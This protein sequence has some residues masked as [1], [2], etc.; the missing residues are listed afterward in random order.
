[1]TKAIIF[2][3]DGVIVSSD[4]PRWKFLKGLLSKR[5]YEIEESY[6]KKTIGKTT[7]LALE[8]ILTE[9]NG[10]SELDSILVE[11]SNVYRE[12]IVQ[13]ILPVK[14]TINFIK[15]YEGSAKLAVAS[16]T[17]ERTLEKILSAY[18]IF[19]KF[20]LVM[21][22]DNI[23]KHKPNP[24]IYEKVLTTLTVSPKDAIVF[25]DSPIGAQAALA[26]GTRCYVMLHE[27]NKKEDF[28]HLD[29]AGF[30]ENEEDLQKIED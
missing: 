14:H 29:I 18:G 4:L 23:V 8:E 2:D 3:F 27:L 30:I 21:G 7:Q 24:E 11:Y 26:A 5:G 20:T 25:E 15:S 9:K 12:N 17:S 6:F 28:A 1:M 13:Y 16:M 22:K 10:L 19:H